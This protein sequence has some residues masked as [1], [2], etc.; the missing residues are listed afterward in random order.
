MVQNKVGYPILS[1][2]QFN[3]NINLPVII[4]YNNLFSNQRKKVK[5][6]IYNTGRPNNSVFVGLFVKFSIRGPT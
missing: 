1:K 3:N 6:V 4:L 5:T 2:Q